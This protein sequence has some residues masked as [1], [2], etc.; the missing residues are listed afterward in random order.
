MSEKNWKIDDYM[1]TLLIWKPELMLLREILLTQDLIEERKWGQP[2]YLYKNTIIVALGTFKKHAT[3]SFFKGALLKD[4]YHLL[5]SPGKNSRHTK[6][7]KFTSV[8]QI[9]EHREHIISYLTEAKSLEDKG[10]KI[11][12][13]KEIK[14]EDYPQELLDYFHELPDFKEAF[15]N[16]TP[17]RRRAYIM[18]F[19]AAKQSKTK[20]ARIEKYMDHIFEKKRI[21]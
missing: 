19:N 10:I 15:Q 18:F 6:Y 16:L 13:P 4:P 17:G 14:I 5:A 12:P 7:F 11:A 3:L 20:I 8:D 2:C 9:K 21:K 1:D